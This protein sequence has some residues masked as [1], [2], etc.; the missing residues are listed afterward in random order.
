MQFSLKNTIFIAFIIHPK[1][2]TCMCGS[3]QKYVKQICDCL[4]TTQLMSEE[5][6]IGYTVIL[7]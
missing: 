7:Q 2:K 6:A 5:L 3:Q 1:A 4:P